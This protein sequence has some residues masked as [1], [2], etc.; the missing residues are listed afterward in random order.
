MQPVPSPASL[1]S[2]TLTLAVGQRREP[3]EIAAYLLDRGFERLDQVEEPGDFAL[4][5]GILDIFATADD[6]PV[7]IEFFGDEIESIRQF[8]VG[9]QRS[10]RSLKT[11]RVTISPDA[12]KAKLDETTT[13]LSY[14]PADTLV[15]FDEPVETAEIART[16]WDR[17]G[18]PD[19]AASSRTC[20]INSLR[21]P[22]SPSLSQQT[23][24]GWS[25]ASRTSCCTASVTLVSKLGRASQRRVQESASA[26]VASGN[27]LKCNWENSANP[28]WMASNE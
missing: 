6:D 3:E 22:R 12:A 27:R 7:R 1:D 18:R 2:H 28:R 4:R 25:W 9:T 17:L 16:I 26:T 8:E 14:L 15:V 10:V 13:F 19:L 20:S 11:A 21:R 24:T 5:G 23:R